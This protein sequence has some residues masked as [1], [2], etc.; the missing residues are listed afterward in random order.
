MKDSGVLSSIYSYFIV[1][2]S[3]CLIM[4]WNDFTSDKEVSKEKQ[5]AGGL[6]DISVLLKQCS[7]EADHNENGFLVSCT[8]FRGREQG[9]VKSP[10]SLP[11]C[12]SCAVVDCRVGHKTFFSA[13]PPSNWPPLIKGW[14]LS[15][16]F[17]FR[18]AL[19]LALAMGM[20]ANM[21]KAEPRKVSAHQGLA[22]LL[23]WKLRH[24]IYLQG[25]LPG[26][27]GT[28]WRKPDMEPPESQPSAD[29][30]RMS[31]PARLEQH[32][33]P[34]IAAAHII[35][36]VHGWDGLWYYEILYMAEFCL[37]MAER[38]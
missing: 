34:Q 32:T 10:P 2:S 27:R 1:C 16:S 33:W 12:P 13:I 17:E 7:D 29:G 15:L 37:V 18:L 4:G 21:T 24:H 14:N 26:G 8:V 22:F 36:S 31:R 23:L 6:S 3:F 9:R 5:C 30:R 20:V 35:G 19:G 25:Y 28:T 11:R 38:F